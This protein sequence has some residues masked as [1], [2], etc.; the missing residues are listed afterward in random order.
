MARRRIRG[1]RAFKKLI[2]R[3]P[4]AI[5]EEMVSQLDE[6]GDQILAAQRA[7]APR[8][9]GALASGLSKR[10]YPRSLRLR[11]GLIGKAINRK[12]YYGRIVQ[13]GRKAQT[14]TA[15]RSTASGVSSYQLRVRAMPGRPFV[16]SERAKSIRNTL[17]GRLKDFWNKVLA[18]ASQGVSDA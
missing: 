17:G 16:H 3:M 18:R 4:E 14:V 9:T 15:R 12:L 1:D 5:R 13:S 8:R 10:L 6:A 7:A 2:R 11:V